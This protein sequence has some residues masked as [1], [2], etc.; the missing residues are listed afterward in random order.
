MEYRRNGRKVRRRL[1][2][3]SLDD[4]EYVE[5]LSAED[6]SPLRRVRGKVIIAAAVRVG[7]TR[8]IDNV[9]LQVEENGN[10]AEAMLFS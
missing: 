2:D 3:K 8:L 5:L 10:V 6:L 9:V 1:A 4:V 7:E